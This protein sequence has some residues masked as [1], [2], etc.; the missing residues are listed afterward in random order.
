MIVDA[1][2]GIDAQ[3]ARQLQQRLGVVDGDP[4]ELHVLNRLAI[5]GFSKPGGGLSAVPHCTYGP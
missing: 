5:L 3:R 2:G 1:V 4:L